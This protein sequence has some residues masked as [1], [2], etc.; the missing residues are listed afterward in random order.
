MYGCWLPCRGGATV[1]RAPRWPRG[2]QRLQRAQTPP[3]TCPQPRLAALTPARLQENRGCRDSCSTAG[4][5]HV[6]CRSRASVP[7]PPR[8][9]LPV[10]GV[11]AVLC[12]ARSRRLGPGLVG[13]GA[14]SPAPGDLLALPPSWGGAAPVPGGRDCTEKPRIYFLGSCPS[15]STTAVPHSKKKKNSLAWSHCLQTSTMTVSPKL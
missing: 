4:H 10:D 7:C 15:S 8:G 3:P 1:L 2:T 5:R 6:P 9:C 13:Q 11:L 14:L 12:C